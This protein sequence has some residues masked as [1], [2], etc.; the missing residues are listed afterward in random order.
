LVLAGTNVR[1][2]FIKEIKT[3]KKII[4]ASGIRF[5]T[6]TVIVGQSYL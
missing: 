2:S 3:G 6:D 4:G 5:S 1:K